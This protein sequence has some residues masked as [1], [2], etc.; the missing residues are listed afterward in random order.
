[1]HSVV[2]EPTQ[3]IWIGTRTTYRATGGGTSGFNT[4]V[5]T[6]AYW[7]LIFTFWLPN[8]I[9]IKVAATIPSRVV[10]L[11]SCCCLCPFLLSWSPRPCSPLIT[12][13]HSSA[14]E[15][16]DVTPSCAFLLLWSDGT[17]SWQSVL[18]PIIPETEYSR[19]C[20]WEANSFSWGFVCFNK[21]VNGLSLF[22]WDLWPGQTAC[23][24]QE[25]GA[26]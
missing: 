22:M 18:H 21:R 10:T 14:Y 4:T 13:S 19:L 5:R 16:V 1:M 7:Y 20:R 24:A 26:W 17:R 12:A 6:N 15:V 2:L 11:F 25:K 8:C 9:T 3:L 23:D